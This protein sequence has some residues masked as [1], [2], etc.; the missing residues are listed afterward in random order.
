VSLKPPFHNSERFIE[1]EFLRAG[2]C[3]RR[4]RTNGF[5]LA[6]RLKFAAGVC[7]QIR[8]FPFA[9]KLGGQRLQ[10]GDCLLEAVLLQNVG[11]RR[12]FGVEALTTLVRGLLGLRP[13]K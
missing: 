9:R 11:G 13:G 6:L 1:L 2:R 5:G 7:Q 4:D 3:L 12:Q 8:G 10:R